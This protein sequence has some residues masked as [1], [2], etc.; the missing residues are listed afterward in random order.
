MSGKSTA[1]M[2]SAV[3]ISLQV[4]G[5][6]PLTFEV[7]VALTGG[8]GSFDVQAGVPEQ[9]KGSFVFDPGSLSAGSGTLALSADDVTVT[10]T[11]SG[12]S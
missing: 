12:G 11:S 6:A 4:G 10:P 9:K 1:L 5:C 3:V 7:P 8:S 2:L